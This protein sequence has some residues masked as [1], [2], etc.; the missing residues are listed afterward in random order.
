MEFLEF[1]KWY[2]DVLGRLL[3][4]PMNRLTKKLKDHKEVVAAFEKAKAELAN[5]ACLNQAL[6]NHIAD[7]DDELRMA[8]YLR[9]EGVDQEAAY[10][11]AREEFV[12]ENA[13]L[14]AEI[15]SLRNGE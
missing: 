14:K 7:L 5:Q 10:Q 1:H 8:H 2:S 12:E 15:E 13:R 3:L 6:L 11:R 4:T 9:N